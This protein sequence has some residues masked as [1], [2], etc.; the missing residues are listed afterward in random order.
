MSFPVQMTTWPIPVALFGGTAVTDAITGPTTLGIIKEG[1]RAGKT[2][3]EL[4]PEIPGY[5]K[6]LWGNQAGH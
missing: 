6:E 2:V 5:A 1:L 4:L 3:S